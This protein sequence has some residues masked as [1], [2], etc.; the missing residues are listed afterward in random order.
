MNI[1]IIGAGNVGSALGLRLLK[2]GHTLYYGVRDVHK[3]A[4]EEL[5]KKGAKFLA[6][7]EAAKVAEAVILA[8]PWSAAEETVKGL[9]DLGGKPLLDATNPIAPG[10]TLALGYDISGGEKVQEWATNA[11]VVKVFN[12]TGS[13]NMKNPEIGGKALTMFYCGDDADACKTAEAIGNAVGFE[14]VAAGGLANARL[15]EPY[16]FLWINLA[17]GLGLGQDI[18]FRLLRR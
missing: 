5:R 8:V 15:L 1:A 9:G 17:F 12:N 2:A 6:P 18:G 14:M 7:A 16:A 10:F 4:Y 11:R 13:E 3:D